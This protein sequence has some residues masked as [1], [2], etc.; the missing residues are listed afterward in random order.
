MSGYTFEHLERTLL[1][2]TEAEKNEAT[3][4]NNWQA[5]PR[6]AASG[7]FSPWMQR[8]QELRA[9]FQACESKTDSW[10]RAVVRAVR[11]HVDSENG[12]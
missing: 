10:R 9:G 6:E 12:R 11:D 4:L 3:A 1:E 7:T 2:L 5:H 8:W